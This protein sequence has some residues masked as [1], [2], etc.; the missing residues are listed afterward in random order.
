MVGENSSPGNG[1]RRFELEQGL[2]GVG[3]GCC[4]V[5]QQMH[6]VSAHDSAT[7]TDGCCFSPR[8][9]VASPANL[10]QPHRS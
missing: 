7:E 1:E 8:T 9:V 2:V 4:V 6:V 3:A 10:L 5:V